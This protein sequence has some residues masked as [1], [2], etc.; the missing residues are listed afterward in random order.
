M[1]YRNAE[2]V[3]KLRTLS[4]VGVAVVF[5]PEVGAETVRHD[6]FGFKIGRDLVILAKV[7]W[8]YYNSSYG[9]A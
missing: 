9:S 5:Y 6:C 2:P 4:G 7:K 8:T 3:Q 1:H